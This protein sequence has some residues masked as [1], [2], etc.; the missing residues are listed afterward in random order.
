MYISG[1]SASSVIQSAE[2]AVRAHVPVL[3]WDRSIYMGTIEMYY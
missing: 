1:E 2:A 3:A